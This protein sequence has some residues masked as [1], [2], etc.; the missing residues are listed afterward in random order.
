VKFPLLSD[1]TRQVSKDYGILNEKFQF[2]N[3]TTFVVDKDGKI[4]HITEG[5][6]AVDPTSA[7]DI[8]IDLHK[9]QSAK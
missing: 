2:A 1:M 3:R 7:I 5:G 8:C 9:K 4:Q 6:S